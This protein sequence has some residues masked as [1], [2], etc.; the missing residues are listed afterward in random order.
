[1]E[2]TMNQKY[3]GTVYGNFDDGYCLHVYY[4]KM[5]SIEYVTF[6]GHD[7]IRL[8][9]DDGKILADEPAIIYELS[10]ESVV[11]ITQ[12][13]R[14]INTGYAMISP[15][16]V[17]VEYADMPYNMVVFT[18]KPVR[19]MTDEQKLG[20]YRECVC[21]DQEFA[22]AIL[23]DHADDIDKISDYGEPVPNDSWLHW[24]NLE[25]YDVPIWGQDHFFPFLTMTVPVWY[26]Y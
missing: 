16:A 8:L 18:R 22:E 23:R 11:Y 17:V 12:N 2:I 24:K 25:A 10:D 3:A 9:S 20:L 1:M 6:A 21:D 15:S 13:F 7:R 5:F 26:V 14:P 19:D 4:P